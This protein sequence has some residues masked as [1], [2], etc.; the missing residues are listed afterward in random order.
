[1]MAVPHPGGQQVHRPIGHII[2][3]RRTNKER[4]NR[5]VSSR[6]AVIN[7]IEGSASGLPMLVG[8]SRAYS[9]FKF[10]EC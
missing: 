1:M 8:T 4:M 7:A 3:N 2:D 9:T 5:D 6:K 10:T